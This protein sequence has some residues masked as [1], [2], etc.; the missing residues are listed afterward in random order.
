ELAF[1]GQEARLAGP[2]LVAT[3]RAPKTEAAFARQGFP[4]AHVGVPDAP[5][6]SAALT[7]ALWKHGE[8]KPWAFDAWV[9]DADATNTLHPESLQLVV[10]PAWQLRRVDHARDALAENGLYA[11]L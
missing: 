1:G 9:P 8:P 5:T 10:P 2:S 3:A 6:L 11:Q 4:V 7:N